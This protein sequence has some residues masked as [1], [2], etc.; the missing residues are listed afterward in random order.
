MDIS[1]VSH[2]SKIFLEILRQ[3]IH[4]F[5]G[6]RNAEEQFDFTS[7]NG[8]AYIILAER[9]IIQKVVNKQKEE[10]LRLIFVDYTKAF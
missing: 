6:P 1:P 4:H 8:T 7:G 3:R 9:N 2:A 10:E 5:N